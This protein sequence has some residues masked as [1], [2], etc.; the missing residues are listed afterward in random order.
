MTACA[1]PQ[2]SRTQVR[3][4][5]DSVLTI[6]NRTQQQN[7]GHATGEEVQ[8]PASAGSEDT[9]QVPLAEQAEGEPEDEDAAA[10]AGAAVPP[11]GVHGQ[12]RSICIHKTQTH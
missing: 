1:A 5:I 2:L 6:T 11:A 9:R 7:P 12:G 3:K 10:A 8:A 4:P